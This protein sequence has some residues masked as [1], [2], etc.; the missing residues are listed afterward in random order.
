MKKTIVIF[1]AGLMAYS[2][3]AQL[4]T[5]N[6][7]IDQFAN[8]TSTGGSTYTVGAT[9]V[10]QTNAQGQVWIGAGTSSGTNQPVITNVNLTV[11][12]LRPGGG[13]A[14]NF[15]TPLG[16]D[17]ILPLTGQTKILGTNVLSVYYSMAFQINNLGTLTSA[18]IFV[19]GFEENVTAGQTT[20]PG[21]IGARLY[22]CKNGSGYNI[23]INKADG[24]ATNYVWEGGATNGATYNL[25]TT[26]FVVASYNFS[27]GENKSDTASL[28]VNPAT[29]TFGA[30]T[31]PTGDPSYIST[32][33]LVDLGGGDINTGVN[34]GISGFELRQGNATEPSSMTADQVHVG[35]TW[36]DVTPPPGLIAVFTNL[37]TPSPITY[38]STVTLSGKVVAPGP[39]YPATNEPVYI[40]INGNAQST[41]ITDAVGDFSINYKCTAPTNAAPYTI[42]Y[43]YLGDTL[44]DGAADTSTTLSVSSP[45]PVVLSGARMYDGTATASAAML[46]VSNSVGADVINIGGGPATL[47]GAGP[48]P[49][50]ITGFGS[51]TLVGAPASNYTLAGV[52][53]SVTIATPPLSVGH[54]AFDPFADATASG[55]TAYNVGDD[56]VGE[57]NAQG[58]SWFAVG[59]GSGEPMVASG[60]LSVP[61]LLPETGNSIGYG[62]ANGT[63]ARLDLGTT[64]TNSTFYGGSSFTIYYSMSYLITETND[65]SATPAII[66]GFTDAAGTQTNSPASII[67]ARLYTRL[68][69]SG[70]N[71]G[72][73]KADGVTNDIAWE[74]N[75]YAVNT[76]NFI[77]AA[78]TFSGNASATNDSV[79]LWV[80]PPSGS[81]G[82]GSIPTDPSYYVSTNAGPNI[83]GNSSSDKISGFLLREASTTEPAFIT[84]DEV[85]VGLSWADVTPTGSVIPT[86]VPLTATRSGGNVVISW[87]TNVSGFRLQGTPVL[88][89]TSNAWTNVTASTNVV[90]TNYSVT[91]TVSGKNY[92]RLIYP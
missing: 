90:G 18:P 32:A 41:T 77:V 33:T 76:T 10:G 48:G 80:N 67:G 1:A 24:V 81:F 27:S 13:N 12:G 92:Y 89:G 85:S 17:A 29:N 35:L 83:G 55:G 56:L 3:H 58:L 34:D 50:A 2:L 72:I 73:N 63:S 60:A 57:T 14:V 59:N 40:N 26:Y 11:P 6:P 23:G 65:L 54:P 88:I 47:A 4:T 22:L 78:Y 82:T 43:T 21:V 45:L 75:T 44:L 52:T 74:T 79:A 87:T 15:G 66:A 61:G 51:L 36:A 31:A 68:S 39:V 53:G 7:E 28:W 91:D 86:A 19:A 20:Q 71:L 69:G 30:A 9:L 46:F 25:G 64:T 62:S 8:A 37:T 42:T 70:F 84:I 38:G 49:E 16:T 5:N